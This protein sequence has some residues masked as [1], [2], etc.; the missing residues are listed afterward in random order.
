MK[1]P[2]RHFVL[3]SG[4]LAIRNHDGI[5]ADFL[6]PIGD[7]IHARAVIGLICIAGRVDE[8]TGLGLV[9]PLR[10]TAGDA[11]LIALIEDDVAI[12][13]YLVRGVINGD[14][15]RLQSVGSDARIDVAFANR[16]AALFRTGNGCFLLTTHI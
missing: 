8:E 5:E 6:N 3:T 7:E 12:G 13:D 10:V 14:F 11:L 4:N 1:A 16:D 15:V 2:L 9:V